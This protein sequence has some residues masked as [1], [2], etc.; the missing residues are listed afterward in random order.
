MLRVALAPWVGTLPVQPL[1]L[2]TPGDASGSA[3]ATAAVTAAITANTG[4]PITYTYV[5]LADVGATVLGSITSLGRTYFDGWQTVATPTVDLGAADM[6]EPLDAYV[7]ADGSLQWA[8]IHAFLRTSSAVY[9]GTVV[10]LP[11][12][13]NVALM[14]WRRD[15]FANASLAPP[16]TWREVIEVARALNSTDFNNGAQWLWWWGGSVTMQRCRRWSFKHGCSWWHAD[17]VRDHALCLDALRPPAP[18]D[19][20]DPNG[21]LSQILASITQS[22]VRM[23]PAVLHKARVPLRQDPAHSSA[24]RAT[25]DCARRAQAR[26]GCSTHRP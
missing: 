19:V 11:L 22:Q 8:D 9:N 6:I 13:A 25:R 7:S 20:N 15:V 5:N 3:A 16:R 23:W 18:N 17:G 2:L 24:L 10:G 12:G 14:H 1:R 21:I 26:A 4:W